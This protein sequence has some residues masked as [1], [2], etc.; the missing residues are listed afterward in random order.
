LIRR[1]LAH[2]HLLH[3]TYLNLVLVFLVPKPVPLKE[4]R[5]RGEDPWAMLETVS[6][7]VVGRIFVGRSILQKCGVMM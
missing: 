6:I 1:V 5:W 7:V 3:P 2:I 4:Q